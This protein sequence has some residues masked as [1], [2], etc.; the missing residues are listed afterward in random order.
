MWCVAGLVGRCVL[1]CVCAREYMFVFMCE[2]VGVCNYVRVCVY[3]V[4]FLTVSAPE[5]SWWWI[6]SPRGPTIT[7]HLLQCV[8]ACVCLG[9]CLWL[10]SRLRGFLHN[11]CFPTVCMCM[12][13]GAC[14][15]ACVRLVYYMY[16]WVHTY[17]FT[18][19]YGK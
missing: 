17:D 10:C 3:C 11:V 14:M 6:F 15:C 13:K 16:T 12:Q 18:Y 7:H 19:T 1:V 2:S 8:G 9:L 5:A 4:S